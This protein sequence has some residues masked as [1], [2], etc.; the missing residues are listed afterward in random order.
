MLGLYSK[1]PIFLSPPQYSL[2]CQSICMTFPPSP[3]PRILHHLRKP[4]LNTSPP[5]FSGVMQNVLLVG[6]RGGMRTLGVL[7]MTQNLHNRTGIMGATMKRWGS[8]R[9]TN[10][11][12]TPT[13]PPTL[14]LLRLDLEAP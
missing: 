4:A 12:F 13:L 10:E 1:P 5:A 3:T 11:S 2:S 14:Q 9:Q 6:N 7:N 8:L